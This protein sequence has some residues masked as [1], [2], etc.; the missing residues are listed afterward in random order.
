[1]ALKDWNSFE[2]IRA[3]LAAWLIM[4]AIGWFIGY[5]HGYYT[6]AEYCERLGSFYVGSKT[7]SCE[8]VKEAPKG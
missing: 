3:D 5:A 8:V 7:F 2:D 6:N 1:M 4:I